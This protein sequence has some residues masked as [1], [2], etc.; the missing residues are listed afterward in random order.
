[1][2][3][4]NINGSR[5]NFPDGTSVEEMQRAASQLAR[6]Q[7][8]DRTKRGAHE[9]WEQMNPAGK[10]V[11]GLTSAAAEPVLG[12]GQLG[13]KGLQKLG[14]NTEAGQRDLEDR[15][16]SV[17]GA[18]EGSGGWGTAGEV[19]GWLAGGAATKGPQALGALATR[20]PQALRAIAAKLS[21]SGL[22]P[23]MARAAGL[24]ATEQAAYEATRGTLPGDPTRME[25]ATSGAL[26]GGAGGALGV[27]ATRTLGKVL[28]PV[29]A[30]DAAQALMREA[31]RLGVKLNLSVGQ[32]AGRGSTVGDI[33]EAV[34]AVPWAGAAVRRMREGGVEG[35]NS[36]K[37]TDVLHTADPFRRAG[38]VVEAGPAGIERVQ[39][40]VKQAYSEALEGRT[41]RS[42]SPNDFDLGLEA[43]RR[44]PPESAGVANKVLSN[45]VDDIASGKIT[46]DS[47]TTLRSSVSDAASKAFRDG[48]YALGKAIDAIDA[49]VRKLISQSGGLRKNVRLQQA[50]AAYAKL[51]DLNRAAAMQGAVTAGGRITPNQ[52]IG[53]MRRGEPASM[54][55]SQRTPGLRQAV[56]A[57]EVLGNTLPKPGPGTAEKL[58]TAG[59]LGTA[60]SGVEKFAT[61][62]EMSFAPGV[63]VAAAYMLLGTPA[64]RRYLV[65]G[66]GP[67]GAANL[68]SE[69]ARRLAAASAKGTV[70]APAAR[71][72]TEILKDKDDEKE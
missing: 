5:I 6:M 54:V 17:R 18:R 72:M 8:L 16:A 10:F 4:V 23:T 42:L 1:M 48:D 15:M 70:R 66:L 49:D 2:P 68:R 24:G 9:T 51:A 12:L 61:G 65:P 11:T 3:V 63:S 31:R 27:A 69:L 22:M 21:G 43:I 36:A 58:L 34:S 46:G 60:A 55:A 13:L 7:E 40:A 52:L 64:G 57:S 33:E 25:R 35:W 37:L 71:S 44:L 38:E 41:L 56:E 26:G 50:D 29:V 32:A 62:D 28:E 45:V 39:R 67:K 19:G 20:G 53:S 14:L 59:L 47:I 30:S